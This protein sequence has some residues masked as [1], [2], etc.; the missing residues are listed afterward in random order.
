MDICEPMIW[1]IGLFDNP[2]RPAQSGPHGLPFIN[3]FTGIELPLGRKRPN[4]QLDFLAH[5][6]YLLPRSASNPIT[7]CPEEI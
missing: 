6:Q 2:S 3:L 7:S 5:I 1:Y 4:T